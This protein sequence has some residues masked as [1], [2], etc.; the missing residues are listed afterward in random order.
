MNLTRPSLSFLPMNDIAAE[1]KSNKA[2][3][4][5]MTREDKATDVI[6]VAGIKAERVAISVT[7]SDRETVKNALN[8]N[9]KPASEYVSAEDGEKFLKVSSELSE[10]TSSEIR[11]LRDEL[12]QL[13][14]ELSKKGFI[15][16]TIKY[17]GFVESFKK[18]NILYEDYIC[19]ISN[20]VIGRSKEVYIAD[21]KMKHFFEEGKTFVIKRSDTKQEQVVMSLGVNNAGKISFE[22]AINFLDSIDKVGIFKT[23]GSYTNSTFSF[24]EIQKSVSEQIERY[25]TQSDDTDTK[26]LTIKR[27]KVGYA[28]SFKVPRNIKSEKGIAGAL[29]KFSIR[30]QAVNTPGGLRCHVV[31]IGSIVSNGQLN[32]KFDNIEDAINKGYVLASSEIVYATRDNMAMENDIYFDFYAGVHT[33]YKNGAVAGDSQVDGEI[34]FKTTTDEEPTEEAVDIFETAD[35]LPI[36]KDSKYCFIIEAL[37]A[38]EESYWR[39]RFSYYNNNEYVDDLHRRNASYVYKAIDTSG[40]TGD[41]KCIQI[42]DDIAKYDLMYTLVIKDI[43]EEEEVAK[44][45]GVYTTRIILPKPINVS[46]ARLTMR[47]NREGMY[48]IKEHNSEYTIFTLESNTS[49][50]HSPSDTRFKINDYI[51]IGNTIA[52]VKR[53]STTE[54]EVF[55][56]VYLDERIVK[57]YTKTIYDQKVDGYIKK[58]S[59]PVYRL[60][61]DSTIKARLVDWESFNEIA[62]AFEHEDITEKPVKLNLVTVIPDQ[63]KTNE[64]TSDRLLFEAEFGKNDKE[65]NLLANEFELQ[66]NWRSPFSEREINETKDTKDRNFKELIGRIHDLSL[67]FDKHY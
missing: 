19:G 57:M 33:N 51:V 17:E 25:H 2:N 48:N 6:S 7:E 34:D 29:S 27:S 61:Y 35:N 52:K 39:L 31:D 18:G 63:F 59:I 23:L 32:P 3:R 54:I 62:G 55:N 60:S 56:P 50:S 45:E 13:Y 21:V 36:L 10:I 58:T 49:T 37:G 43:I 8:L 1:L 9:G 15:D 67:A 30:A 44:Q 65:N 42:I 5:F 64:R 46:R 66:V 14:A 11:N 40:I 16:N 12:Y 26:Y 28:V 4:K 47:V 41:E 22:P 38:T 53:V 24:S 20:A